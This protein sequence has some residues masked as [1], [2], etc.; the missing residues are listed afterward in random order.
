MNHHCGCCD[1]DVAEGEWDYLYTSCGPCAFE[2]SLEHFPC[3]H[4]E[5]WQAEKALQHKGNGTP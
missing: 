5:A 1:R 2:A 4:G 3:D